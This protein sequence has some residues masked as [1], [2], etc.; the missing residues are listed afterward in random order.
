MNHSGTEKLYWTDIRNTVKKT[1]SD[2]YHLVN[3]LNPG[4]DFPLYLIRF[5]YGELIGDKSSQFLPI[6]DKKFLRLNDPDLP[7]EWQQH[8]GYGK[9]SSHQKKDGG[10]GREDRPE[11]VREGCL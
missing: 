8:L 5:P 10:N 7:T 6:A 9:K 11:L 1:N 3:A 2:F 4:H